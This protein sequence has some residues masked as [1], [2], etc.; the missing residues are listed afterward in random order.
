MKKRKKVC[1]RSGCEQRGESKP[2]LTAARSR[3][4]RLRAL[5]LSPAAGTYGTVF[6][7]FDV[8]DSLPIPR[9]TGVSQIRSFLFCFLHCGRL[10]GEDEDLVPDFLPA[11]GP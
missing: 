10:D 8:T 4:L 11:L 7:G 6:D 9:V 3:E 1:C 2:R 5:R